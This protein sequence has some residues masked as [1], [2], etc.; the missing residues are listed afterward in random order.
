MRD[1][2]S[3]DGVRVARAAVGQPLD[4]ESVFLLELKA[5]HAVVDELLIGLGR[6]FLLGAI[7]AVD[8]AVRD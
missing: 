4:N 8:F 1:G 7:V 3:V 2:S 5:G 6:D